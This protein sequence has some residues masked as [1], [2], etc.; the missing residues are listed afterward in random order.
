MPRLLTVLAIL[1][2]LGPASFTRAAA[3][4][5]AR[6]ALR[7]HVLVQLRGAPL[8][9]DRNL[10]TRTQ[11]SH[12]RLRLDVHLPTSQAYDGA[13]SRYQADEIQYLHTSGVDVSVGRQYHLLFNGFAATVPIDQLGQLEAA[14]NVQAVL[15]VRHFHP[16][17][18][19]SLK[20]VHASEAWAQVGGQPNAGKN[21][22]IANIDS[23][24]DISNPCF[25]DTHMA[26]PGNGFPTAD[27]AANT[28]LTNNKVIVARAFG[29]D[30]K[31]EYSAKDVVGHGTFTGAIEA[32]D[33]GT[34][35]P[36]GTTI[37]GVAPAAYLMSYNVFPGDAATAGSDT[38]IL[39]ALEKA[40]LDGA[41]V[42]NMSLGGGLGAGDLRFDS[43]A[44]AVEIAI[45][46]GVPVVASAGNAGPTNQTVSSPAATPNAI[47]VG[48]TTNSHALYSSI[49]VSSSTSVPT[50][51]ASIEA[52]PGSHPWSGLIGPAQLVS[53]GFGRKPGND[54]N[55]PTADDFAGKDLQGKIALIQRGPA[56]VTFEQKVNNAAKAGAI[57]VVVYDNRDEPNLFTMTLQ[58]ATLPATLISLKNGQALLQWLRDHPDTQVTMHSQLVSFDETPNVISSYSSRGDAAGYA[59]K[60]DL[61]APGQDIYSATEK[62][63]PNN[64]LWDPSGFTSNSGTSFSAPHVTG[65]VALLLQKHSTWTPGII[66]S[67]LMDTAGSD[68]YTSAD[69][70]AAPPIM[71]SGAGLL[72]IGKAV[73]S[74]AELSPASVTF[75]ETNI[76]AGAVSR[77]I[78]VSLA[79]LGGG[80]GAWNVSVTPLHGAT[81]ISVSVPGSVTLTSNGQVSV[82]IQLSVSAGTARGD[83]DGYVVLTHNGETLHVPYFAHVIA[84]VVKP[85]SILLVDD[86]MSRFQ[87][88]P[89]SQPIPRVDVAHWYTETLTKLG[90]SYIYWNEGILGTPSLEDMKLASAVI[91][92]TG[93]NLEGWAP[94]NADPEEV[95][96]ALRSSDVTVLD[97]YL[98]GG[99]RLFMSGMNA[100]LSDPYFSIVLLGAAPAFLLDAS[101]AG[102]SSLYDN[103]KNDKKHNG[104]ILP[105]KPSAVVDNFPKTHGNRWLFAGLK[106]IDFSGKGD[107]ARDN[108]AVYSPLI[109]NDFGTGLIGVPGLVPIPRSVNL[110]NGIRA[111]GQAALRTTA[112]SLVSVAP[113]V[114]VV[115][116]DEPS[117]KRK[118]SYRGRSVLF[119]FGFEGINNNTGYATRE[120]VM[121]RVLSWLSD[122]PA[123]IVTQRNYTVGRTVQ[124]RARDTKGGAAKQYSWQ[125]GNT[126]LP[127]STKATTYRFPHRGQY[128]LR[129]AITDSL[130]HISISPRATVVVR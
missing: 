65:A 43:I 3:A 122:Q 58:S 12:W 8:A 17:L 129:V 130:G 91:Y 4:T 114:A 2:V 31:K 24:I 100:V 39:G 90:K 75:G 73:A 112:L 66:K 45:K 97:Q 47:A 86:T 88:Q 123:A 115:S 110:G 18:D 13:V 16:L 15:P 120:Q 83:Y 87:P 69:K 48:M 44:S 21:I 61:V 92:F 109:S 93:N 54:P 53:A 52:A 64:E 99:G 62:T 33:A 9:S 38:A 74:T 41:D 108:R 107:G 57:G 127:T 46:A 49:T 36:L 96:G 116:S 118:A 79:D 102:D 85:G 50:N 14:A 27:T 22:R 95:A 98:T 30:A 25:S 11:A 23:G 78:S 28:K 71:E 19:H 104:G 103:S 29:D 63:T 94:Q 67:V 106:A 101:A 89:P 113:D 56:P 70:S 77:S 72:D 121:Q 5:P 42:I 59:I 128:Q 76:G 37:S 35:T 34:K 80:A 6:A 124:L 26:P 105:P 60:P 32:C 125:V 111:H 1:F 10:Q 40:L 68:V 84:Q 82:P 81:G 51:T 117:F 20:L 7:I 119:A 55:S 126:T